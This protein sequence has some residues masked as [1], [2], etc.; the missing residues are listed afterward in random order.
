LDQWIR[1]G[2]LVAWSVF[3][4]AL[5][6]WWWRRR[7][8]R[9][10][11]AYTERAVAIKKAIDES[12]DLGVVYWSKTEK[13]F[14]RRLITP[15]E[16]DGYA[17]KAFDHSVNDVRIFQV[18]RFKTIEIVPPGTKKL[19]SLRSALNPNWVLAGIGVIAIGF[20]AFALYRGLGAAVDSSSAP[21]PPPPEIPETNVS[22]S[23]VST[24]TVTTGTSV[25]A[26]ATGVVTQQ[27]PAEVTEPPPA[28]A[29]KPPAGKG[30][31][32]RWELV[33]YDQ[34]AYDTNFVARILGKLLSASPADS[35]ELV[36]II[37][38]QGQARVWEGRWTQAEILRQ[39]FDAEGISV[40]LQQVR[41]QP[42]PDAGLPR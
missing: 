3:G 10:K 34:A 30:P 28:P 38:T 18:T 5:L 25:V 39:T 13:R 40:R 41:S 42:A 17:L 14:L 4:I 27:I 26:Q 7:Y 8:S 11:Y 29:P 6:I 22:T 19:P 31:Q 23:A 1:W 2:L 35:A 15:L 36:R 12:A 24:A 16:L 21:P 32:D 20:L 9:L 33:V 37:R